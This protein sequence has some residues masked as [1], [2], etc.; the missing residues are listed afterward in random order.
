MTLVLSIAPEVFGVLPG[1]RVVAVTAEGMAPRAPDEIAER[2]RRAWTD[3]HHRFGLANAQSHP[4]VQ[5]W[6]TAMKRAGVSHKDHPTS[7]EALVRRALKSPEPFRVNASVDFYNA[8]SLRHVV[9]AGAYDLEALPAPLE[10]RLSRQ[11]DRFQALDSGVE[12]EVPAGELSYAAGASVVTRHLVWRQS[13]LGL[14][15]AGTRSAV[16]VSEIL[17]GQ[18]EL[19]VEVERSLVR[20]LGDLFGA[21][22]ASAVLSEGAPVLHRAAGSRL[23]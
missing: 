11:G 6:R 18:E 16:F 13:R 12:E 7:I 23:E 14:V 5:S 17:P 4:H 1:L 8:V 19:A 2:W 15:T 10:L 9:P 20:G 3:I 21:R 22:V